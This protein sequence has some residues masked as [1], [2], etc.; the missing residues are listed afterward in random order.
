M[1]KILLP[2]VAALGLSAAAQA[3]DDNGLISDQYIIT[4]NAGVV[5]EL[6]GTVE[7]LLAALPGARELHRYDTVLF[8]FAANMTAEQAALL[9]LNPLVQAVEQDR[10]VVASATQQN[11]TW[12]IDR[13]DQRDLPL[14][15]GYSYPNGAGAGAHVYIIDTGINPDH[16]EFSGRLGASR[17]FVSPLL[18]G[19]ADPDDWDDCNGHGTHVASTAAGTTWGVAKQATIHTVRVLDCQGTGSGSAII[20][21]MEWVADNAEHPAVANMSLGTLN[22]RSQAQE[23]AAAAM[24]N[25]GIL[26]VVAAGNDSTNACNTSPA[27]EPLAFTIASSDNQDRQSSFSNHGPC[28]DLFAPGSSITAAH[29]NNNTGSQTM[30]GTSMASPHVAGAAAVELSLSPNA[31]PLDI[32]QALLAD[33]TVGTLTQVSSNTVNKLLYVANDGSTPPV[34]NAPNAAFSFSCSDLDCSFDA[35]GSSDDYGIASYSWDFG[36]GNSGTGVSPSHSYAADGS[37]TV[38][39]TVTDTAAQSDAASQNVTVED[40]GGNPP[41]Q[42]TVY[43]GSLSGSNDA[44][45]HPAGGFEFSGGT[46]TGELSGPAGTDFDLR[47]QKYSCFLYCSWG[48]VAS[49]TSNSSQESISYNAGSGSY[50]WKVESYSGA[51]SYTLVADPQ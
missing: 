17:N 37:Y 26:P 29:Y 2:I 6:A 36:D 43:E 33:A 15:G 7:T 40:G 28:V 5:S 27:A 16:V 10:V 3:A 38:T 34:D 48:N 50:R 49:A 41:P 24:Y 12:G 46:I 39:L 42:G 21:G 32:T 22:G 47:L 35:S 11:A 45:Y 51:G 14:D 30:S 23:D 19:S 1:R 13:V 31:S 25:A 4:L 8:G 20:A 9:A 44:N 18:F